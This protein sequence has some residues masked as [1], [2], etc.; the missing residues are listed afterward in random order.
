MA[1]TCRFRGATCHKCHRRGHIAKACLRG[2][3]EGT[4]KQPQHT[5]HKR[6]AHHLE[7]Q[8]PSHSEEQVTD[9]TLFQV[10]QPSSRKPITLSIEVNGQQLPMELDTGAA[11]SIISTQTR[12][13]MFPEVPLINTSFCGHRWLNCRQQF[14]HS[15]DLFQLKLPAMV[16]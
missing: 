3:S 11:V 5:E 8:S 16:Q 2:Q 1:N 9:I 12:Q 4:R 13:Q 7:E 10:T 6:Q 14:V 15:S